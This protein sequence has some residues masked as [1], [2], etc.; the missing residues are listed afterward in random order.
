M[1]KSINRDRS[2]DFSCK[3]FKLKVL[4]IWEK[5]TFSV[6]GPAYRRLGKTMAKTG[7][8]LQGS[9]ASDDR[10]TRSSL[11]KFALSLSIKYQPFYLT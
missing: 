10:S 1:I 7:L 8:N 5:F 4:D 6:V 9:M 2:I 11:L 3:M